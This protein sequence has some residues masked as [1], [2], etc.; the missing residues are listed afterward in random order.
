MD[1]G[2]QQDW[3]EDLQQQVNSLLTDKRRLEAEGHLLRGDIERL[4]QKFVYLENE[5]DQ[6]KLIAEGFANLAGN[7]A[8]LASKLFEQMDELLNRE[9]GRD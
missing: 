7:S 8:G 1:K 5:R 3:I 4:E 9:T 6:W 2:T